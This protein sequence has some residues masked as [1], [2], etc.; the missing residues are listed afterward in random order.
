MIATEQGFAKRTEVDE[1][2][3]QA[4]GGSGF[5]AAK[6]DKARGPIVALVNVADEL[7]FLAADACMVVPGQ[8]VRAA[9]RDGGGSKTAPEGLQR[10]VAV[11]KVEAKD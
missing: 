7:A 9:G 8:G 1:F 10:V 2:P 11:A 4:R 5:K 3:V 6:I